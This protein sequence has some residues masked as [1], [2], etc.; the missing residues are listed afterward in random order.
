MIHDVLSYFR[1]QLGHNTRERSSDG[2]FLCL[3]GAPLKTEHERRGN[4]DR[5]G[6]RTADGIPDRDE[7]EILSAGLPFSRLLHAPGHVRFDVFEKLR[8]LCI[9]QVVRRRY[10]V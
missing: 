2:S 10:D 7:A 9:L 4:S 8:A 5:G 1:I 6:E 3:R